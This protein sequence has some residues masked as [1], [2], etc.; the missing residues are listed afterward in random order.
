[1]RL[2]SRL[3]GPKK[4]VVLFYA[5]SEK[6][7]FPD[8]VDTGWFFKQLLRVRLIFVSLLFTGRYSCVLLFFACCILLYYSLA[9]HVGL[10]NM[11]AELIYEAKVIASAVKNGDCCDQCQEKIA[12]AA[13][14]LMK[15]G[16]N[17]T[18]IRTVLN[19]LHSDF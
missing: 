8:S 19:E 6:S 14:D 5:L 12:N 18:V 2:L 15:N 7:N 4:G 1:V 16:H 11:E 10:A 17:S 3:A 13:S 9:M